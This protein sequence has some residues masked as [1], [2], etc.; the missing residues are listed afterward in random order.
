MVTTL[1]QGV[2]LDIDPRPFMPGDRVLVYDYRL[3]TNDID[4]PVSFCTK[5]G[6]IVCRY[7]NKYKYTGNIAYGD[8]GQVGEPEYWYYPDLVDIKFDHREEVSKGHFTKGIE[9]DVCH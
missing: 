9:Y 4:T 7:G 1:P 2:E 3:H 6:T 5:P 8:Y